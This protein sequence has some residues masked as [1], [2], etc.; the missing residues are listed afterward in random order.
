[1]R[2]DEQVYILTGE[3]GIDEQ[4]CIFIGEFDFLCILIWLSDCALRTIES[5]FASL[6]CLFKTSG[7][8]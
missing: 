1:M 5:M 4:V 2:I 6:L 7:R 3:L 8:V